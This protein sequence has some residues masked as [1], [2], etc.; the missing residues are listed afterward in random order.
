V[1][2]APRSALREGDGANLSPAVTSSPVACLNCGAALSGKYCSECGQPVIDPNPT[3]RELAHELAEGFL[4][5]DGKLLGTLRM[6][7]TSPGTLTTEYLAGRRVRFISPL[8]VYLTCSFLY[9]FVKAVLPDAPMQINGRPAAVGKGSTSRASSVQIGILTVQQDDDA[10]SVKELDELAKRDKGIA[11]AW[12]RHFGAALRDSR[13]LATA[14]KANVPRMMFVLV[15]LYA[16]LVALV[17]RRRRMRYPQHLAFA[18]HV[19][20]FLFLALLPTL[21]TRVVDIGWVEAAFVLTSFVLIAIHLVLATRRVYEVST[22]GAIA[23]S[24][25]IGA[26]YFV[27]FVA[28]MI[29]LFVGV[30]FASF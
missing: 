17:F 25:L 21:I 8:R 7:V 19:H 2:E 5:W 27:A 24:A 22:G 15:P 3:L 9:F 20:A 14:V 16:A 30:V 1:R 13:K 28:A 12:G 18:L 23:R 6:L 26:A 4:N 11:G 29:A 10:Q